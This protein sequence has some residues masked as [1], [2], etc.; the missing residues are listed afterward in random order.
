MDQ[1]AGRLLPRGDALKMN[2]IRLLIIYL[3][4]SV[5]LS[6]CTA[7]D[8]LEPT[9]S[10]TELR[11]VNACPLT[12]PE[13]LVP[14]E[15]PAVSGSPEYGYYYVNDD[16]SIWASAWWHGTEDYPLRAGEEGLKMGWFRPAG[17][18]LEI[19][20]HRL[21]GESPPLEAHAPCCY[22][23][24]FQATGLVFPT[25]GCWEVSATAADKQLSF[26]LWVEP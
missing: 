15:D 16:R 10:P 12:E 17:V 19:S 7:I 20:G 13:W 1:P 25:G 23:T 11:P 4:L 9:P 18:T 24:R 21:D 5:I 22:P 26:I 6:G 3:L 2:R 14:P 8:A